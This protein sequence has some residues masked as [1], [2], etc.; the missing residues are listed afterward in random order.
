MPPTRRTAVRLL[1][2]LIV[3]LRAA[4]PHLRESTSTVAR[5][6]ELARA[7]LSMLRLRQGGG[8]TFKF[9]VATEATDA[10]MPPM[11]LLPLIDRALGDLTRSTPTGTSLQIALR[12][13]EG[14]LRLT[15]TATGSI[16]SRDRPD[17]DG[18][19][20]VGE[21]LRALYGTD[22]RVDV[23]PDDRPRVLV[24][25]DIPHERTDRDHR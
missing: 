8:L 5:E 23:D 2:E 12:A 4:L 13:G 10:G 25:L 16:A 6:V 11:I 9:D 21:R 1:D 22:A 17:R 24:T 19:A 3:Y 18:I 14:R 20:A 15:L 7:Y